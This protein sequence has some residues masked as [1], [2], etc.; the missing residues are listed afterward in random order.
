MNSKLVLFAVVAFQSSI[1]FAFHPVCG[2]P[3]PLPLND[4]R[5]PTLRKNRIDSALAW[6]KCV[7][8]YN[9]VVQEATTQCQDPSCFQKLAED[10]AINKGWP[11]IKNS[12][13]QLEENTRARVLESCGLF[14]ETESDPHRLENLGTC[15]TKRMSM[16]PAEG[17]NTAQE[18]AE[19]LRLLNSLSKNPKIV[20]SIARPYPRTP[21]ES[22]EFEKELTDWL[23]IHGARK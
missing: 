6:A 14:S 20:R 10:Y 16:I 4:P 2:N 15:I 9:P 3:P 12:I 19:T 21:I 18:V 13:F 22:P 7:E 1:A 17:R 5:L 8:K 11:E 23:M